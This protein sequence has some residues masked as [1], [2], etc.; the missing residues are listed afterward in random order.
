MKIAYV[1]YDA[2]YYCY[3][4]LRA[5]GHEISAVYSFPVDGDY[6][7]NT[8]LEA[9]AKRENVPFSTERITKEELSRLAENGTEMLFCAGYIYRLP[10]D[11][12][13]Y[14]VNFHPAPLPVGR[15][16]WPMP[17]AILRG[18][19]E[20][21]V[22]LHRIA[23]E[24]DSGALLA[25]RRFPIGN[26]NLETLLLKIEEQARPM[27]REIFSDFLSFYRRAEP[28]SGGEYWQEPSEDATVIRPSTPF[29]E[30]ERIARA[31]YGYHVRYVGAHETVT[32]KRAVV[33][34][35]CP[36]GIPSF[37]VSGG[38][39]IPAEDL[40]DSCPAATDHFSVM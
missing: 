23:A 9:A 1:G 24:F 31:F 40:R 25:V 13:L 11:P 33:K 10:T 2:F 5:A 35:A 20:Y 19:R 12:R 6:E 21:G 4:E 27:I 39:L 8:R 38:Y 26:E 16:A 22:A 32:L 18:L 36:A 30:A 37:P 14:M 34:E 17:V 7:T 28:Q 29:S 15:G 3:E